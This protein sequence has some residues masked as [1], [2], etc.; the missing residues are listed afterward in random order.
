[1]ERYGVSLRIHFEYRKIRTRKNFLFG[2][3]YRNGPQMSS[4]LKLAKKYK[5]TLEL[6][7]KIDMKL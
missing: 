7:K 4:V 6:E 5:V 3:F 1:M 2:C